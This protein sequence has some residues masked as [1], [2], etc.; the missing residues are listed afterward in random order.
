[1]AIRFLCACG[2]HLSAL[3]TSAGANVKCP[4]CGQGTVLPAPAQK[5]L[6]NSSQ[7]DS[8]VSGPD[9]PTE[10]VGTVIDASLGTRLGAEPAV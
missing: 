1:M 2:R 6:G 7:N 8:A 10:Q 4:G 5:A 9:L 3:E